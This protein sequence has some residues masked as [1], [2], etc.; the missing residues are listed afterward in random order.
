MINVL[1]ML[2]ETTDKYGGKTAFAD[3]G[4]QAT[5]SEA[6]DL[7]QKIGSALAAGGTQRRAVAVLVPKGVKELISFFGVVYSGN[8]CAHRHGNAGGA[9]AADF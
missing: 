8:L 7:A 4:M 9:D 3:S 6:V 5:Y 1:E 2:E